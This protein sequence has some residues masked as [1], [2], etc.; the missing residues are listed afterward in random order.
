MVKQL[1]STTRKGK[2]RQM[3]VR[4]LNDPCDHCFKG[5]AVRDIINMKPPPM[6]RP[7][8]VVDCRS[9]TGSMPIIGAP[10]K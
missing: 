7:A 10:Q 8:P 9:K 3:Q 5:Q 1:A 4:L 6:K 2:R